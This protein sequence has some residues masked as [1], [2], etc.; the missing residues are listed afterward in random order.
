MRLCVLPGGCRRIGPFLAP[1]TSQ[2][3]P[4]E[5]PLQALL[6][7]VVVKTR[8]LLTSKS[9]ILVARLKRKRRSTGEAEMREL[10]YL[11]L[12]PEWL[13]ATLLPVTSCPILTFG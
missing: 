7:I 3:Q 5:L 4:L 9:A 6:W 10:G 11:R 1:M 8:R 12:M 2:T 13:R